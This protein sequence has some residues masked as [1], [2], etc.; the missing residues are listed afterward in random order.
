MEHLS[1]KVVFTSEE[2]RKILII[3]TPRSSSTTLARE[4]GKVINGKVIYEPYNNYH[5]VSSAIKFDSSVLPDRVVVKTMIHHSLKGVDRYGKTLNDR[6]QST[7]SFYLEEIKK[8]DRVILLSRKDIKGAYESYKYHL[9]TK[10][11]GRWHSPYMYEKTNFDVRVYNEFL[12]WNSAIIEFSL[13][14]GIEINW[15]EDLYSGDLKE[16]KEVVDPWNLGESSTSIYKKLTSTKKY[17]ITNQKN[18][19][20]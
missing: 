11:L 5:P 13:E 20:I 1:E 19:L 17:R 7:F 3:A 8:Y 4:L 6:M 12:K 14:T 2:C 16:F 10:P 9:D 18:T 15:Y